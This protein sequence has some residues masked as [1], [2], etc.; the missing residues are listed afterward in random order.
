MTKARTNAD[1]ASADI[2]GVTAGTG[3]SGGGTSGTVTLD[4]D[5]A[6]V[7]TTSNTLTMSNKTLTSPTLTTPALGTP[8][9]GTLTNCTGLPVAGITAST[10]TALGVGSIELGHATDTSIARVS[11]GVVSIEG[12]NVVTVSSTDTLT[13]KT[14][15][16]PTITT[17]TF[18][19]AT[20]SS[21]TSGRM[22]YDSTNKKIQ[23]GDG[24]NA[25]DYA[26][27][28]LVTNAQTASYTLVLADKDKLVEV[29]N[30]S[31]NTVTIPTN[32][33]VAYPT[34]TQINIL[35]TGAGQTT[36]SGTSGVTVNSTGATTA[37]PKLRAQWSS[38]TA[39][40]RGTDSWVVI[41]DIA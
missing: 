27:S 3:L 34:G 21:T 10:T 9:S 37:S 29:S 12:V 19:L 39:I 24:S 8:A 18:T 2:Q 31:A 23:V 26:S 20:T 6:V 41:G 25:L 7:A 35:Q 1:N 4:V 30:A 14:L 17:P 11:A 22:S 33:S 36:I 15:T 13:N 32:A 40:K 5:T 38:A 28:T 16:S